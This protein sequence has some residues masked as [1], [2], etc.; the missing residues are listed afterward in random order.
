MWELFDL[1]VW[2]AGSRRLSIEEWIR[3]WDL[4][5]HTPSTDREAYR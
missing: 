5:P 2:Y 4:T 3:Q 1:P